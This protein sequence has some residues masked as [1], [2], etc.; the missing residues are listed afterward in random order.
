MSTRYSMQRKHLVLIIAFSILTIAAT[1]FF[2]WLRSGS[3]KEEE[4]SPKTTPRKVSRINQLAQDKRPFVQLVPHP[5]PARCD[6]ISLLI[7]NLRNNET[8]AEY[9]LEYMA[10]PLIQGVFGRRNFTEAA[11]HKPLELGSCSKGKCT[12]DTNISGGSLTLRFAADEE[13]TLKGDFSYQNVS[14]ANGVI[15]SRDVKL[16]L[17]VG[18]ALPAST[19]VI[20]AST[21]GLPEDMD[22]EVVSGPYGI[23]APKGVTPRGPMELSVQT[24]EENVSLY[25]W[26]GTS[27]KK[28][29]SEV[30]NGKITAE[31]NELGVAVLVK[32][33]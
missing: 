6:G 27:W 13:Y 12:C 10:G 24:K 32:N 5:D 2:F 28:L 14:E 15:T 18:S 3:R 21:F 16:S 9:E 17:D 23:F 7:D 26:D 20:I 31:I 22:G 25:F 30:E 8:L 4:I 19:T 29:S 1:G 11:E 33:P